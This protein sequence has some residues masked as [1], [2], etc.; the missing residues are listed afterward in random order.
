MNTNKSD[1]DDEAIA[2][3]TRTDC[4]LIYSCLVIAFV[5]ASSSNQVNLHIA[6]LCLTFLMN[7]YDRAKQ[8][9]MK[10]PQVSFQNPSIFKK[11][12]G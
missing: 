7:S 8:K 5:R 1:D 6:T 9:K 3:T 11:N 12:T 2:S 4:T 10:T